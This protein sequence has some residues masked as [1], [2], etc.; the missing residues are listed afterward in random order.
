MSNQ[1]VQEGVQTAGGLV[2]LALIEKLLERGI[3][4]KEDALDVLNSAARN[5]AALPS[6]YNAE[7]FLTDI[8]RR[9]NQAR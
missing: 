9:I 1:E 2:A 5:T 6:A 8:T 7:K 3:L 4:S